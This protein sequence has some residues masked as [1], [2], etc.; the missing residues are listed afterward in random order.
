MAVTPARGAAAVREY[1]EMIKFEHSIFALPFAMI[2]MLWAAGGWP[3]ART[4]GWIV[5]A[6]VSCRS[7]AMAFNRLV[8]RDIDAKNART[9]QRAIPSGRLRTREVWLFFFVSCALF[10]LAAWMLNPLALMLSPVA[11]AVTLGYSY[12]KRITASTHFLL[13]LS[14]GIAPAAAWIGTTGSLH[15]AI[16]PLVVAVIFWTAGFDILYALQDD[17]FDRTHGLHS[18]PQALG[19]KRAIWI[20]RACHAL[21][22]AALIGAGIVV[23]T[24]AIYF[25]GVAVVAALLTYEQL[26][27]EPDDLSRINVAFFT[28]NG[29]VSIGLLLFVV[30]DL[31][32]GH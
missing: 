22:V 8:D 23:G 16:V 32:L 17:E 21:S 4:F 31:A 24:G 5:V 20:S 19:R 6:M 3:G 10:V 25:V 30:A 7:A 2:G 15:W 18:V 29:F 28:L 27:I 1:L 11:L 12:A 9:R 14:L 13:G 26:L